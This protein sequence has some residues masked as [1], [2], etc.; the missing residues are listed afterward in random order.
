MP[1]NELSGLQALQKIPT[2]I[3]GLD[4]ITMGGIT[5]G[6]MVL[7]AGS[8]GSCKTMLGVEFL[9]RRISEF[10]ASGVFVTF[11]ERPRDIARNVLSIGWHLDQFVEQGKLIF[12]DA[13]PNPTLAGEIGHYDLSGLIAQIEYAVQKIGAS[14]I[15]I[16]SIGSL[17]SQYHD[18]G[19]VRLN[20]YQILSSLGNLGITGLM[21]AER[22]EGSDQVSRNG[23]E[24]FVSDNVIVLR[25]ALEADKCRRTIQILKVRGSDHMKG[26]F[27][28]AV[29]S[30]G[31]S[32][33][34]LSSMSLNQQSANERVSFGNEDLDQMMGGG[35][36]RDA[37]FL[38]SGP[39]GGG[40]T[41]LCATFA[42]AA[43]QQGEKVI[44]LAFEESSEQLKRNAQSWGIDFDMWEQKGLLKIVCTYPEAMSMED[45]LLKIQAE[46]AEFAPR[47]IIL[48]STSAIER[49]S[50]LR[51][52]REFIIAFTSYVKNGR[53]CT[54]IT[55]TTK[56]LS[57]GD[58]VTEGH[59]ST[60]T[61][62]IGLIR[63]VEINGVLRRGIAVIKMRGSQHDK[64]VREFT[65]DDR[66]LHVG[67]PFKNIQNIILGTPTLSGPMEV[68]QLGEMFKDDGGMI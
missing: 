52:F 31:I 65:I 36:F 1:E 66:G 32:I 16:D 57:G 56:K 64:E 14:C 30:T 50:T 20:I 35:L 24:E 62:A 42:N 67:K 63:Y 59:I 26:E 47:R 27:P 49:I 2:G 51:N 45:H 61:D 29:S 44:M 11:E 17:F 43:C 15:V 46:I 19:M 5:E 9:Y 37:I 25:N 41:L 38:L 18:L 53:I 10:G 39:T 48:D 6:R 8:S 28:F 55:S 54:L 22:L 33:I 58:S 60:I 3:D 21:T 40:K 13:S 34:P 23:I 7:V 12:I 68:E 4:S